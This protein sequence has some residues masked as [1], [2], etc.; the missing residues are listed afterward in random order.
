MTPKEKA[1][2]LIEDFNYALTLKDCALVTV[3]EILNYEN[4]FLQNEFQFDY[5]KQ[6]Q[7]EIKKL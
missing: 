7:Q 1:R 4:E 3:N 6:V 5:W 2:E